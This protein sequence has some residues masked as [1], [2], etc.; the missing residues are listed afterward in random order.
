MDNPFAQ[1]GLQIAWAFLE[2]VILTAV[3]GVVGWLIFQWNKW[4][5]YQWDEKNR[6]A[7]QSA[8]ENGVRAGLQALASQRGYQS[9]S[10]LEMDK[11]T[12]LNFARSYVAGSVP[13]A[14]K[15]FGLSPEKIEELAIPHLPIPGLPK[16]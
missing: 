1:I 10:L 8:L 16:K 12:V 13:G 5:R 4:F 9:A 11:P 2:P 3:S 7:L 6:Q 15:H 14:I